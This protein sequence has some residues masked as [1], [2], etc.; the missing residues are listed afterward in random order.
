MRTPLDSLA[1][2]I[3]CPLCDAASDEWCTRVTS[4]LRATFLHQQRYYDS[5]A[6]RPLLRA[7]GGPAGNAMASRLPDVNPTHKVQGVQS[8]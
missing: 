1:L 6:V 4:G 3:T 5:G 2:T 8:R 7:D